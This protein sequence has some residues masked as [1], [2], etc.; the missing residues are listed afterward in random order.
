M[1]FK[2]RHY[3]FT[4]WLIPLLYAAGALIVG[5]TIP[6]LAYNVL[7]GLVSTVS[8]NAA[9][10]IY[11]S[12]ASG[13]IALTGIV[14]SLTFVMVQFSATAYSPRLVLWIARDPVISHSLG[15]FTATFL[16]AIAALA[17]VDRSGSG[18]VPL[19]GTVIVTALLIVSVIMFILLIQ[20]VSML[21]V[22]RMLVFTADQ[23][24]KVI[25]SLYPALEAPP[26]PAAEVAEL[27]CLQTVL[28]HGKPRIVQEVDVQGLVDLAARNRCVIEMTVSVGDAAVES[29]P[30]LRVWGAGEPIPEEAMRRAIRLGGERTF[31]QDPKYAIRLVADIAIKA[32]SPAINDPTTAVQALDQIEDLLIRLGKRRLEIGSFSDASGTARVLMGF[33]AWEDFL[34]LAFDEICFYGAS[35][36]QVMRRMRAVVNELI[37]LLPEER[38]RA[39]G[40]WQDRLQQT[41]ERSFADQRD[42]L[43][44]S[45][46]DRQGLGSTRRAREGG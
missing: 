39:L 23:G 3:Y 46:E 28:H 25:E 17:W 27:P 12:I 41:V 34:R 4:A 22:N 14:F 24:R 13:M 44:A 20:R 1:A 43:D 37:S 18:R 32:L 33:P 15:V 31:E 6:R 35:S 30:V 5:F 29:T 21:Q 16:Y 26:S 42:K 8:V 40:D 7:P 9:I 10:G 2:S 11:S 45:A 19:S 36:V 38:R